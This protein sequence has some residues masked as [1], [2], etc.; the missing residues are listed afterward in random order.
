MTNFWSCPTWLGQAVVIKTLLSVLSFKV[1][2]WAMAFVVVHEIFARARQTSSLRT[3]RHVPAHLVT[4]FDLLFKTAVTFTVV[5]I[6][7]LSNWLV[8]IH[9]L[10]VRAT[11]VA[12][13]VIF[14]FASLMLCLG[15]IGHAES[16]ELRAA[17]A[18]AVD[19]IAR[20]ESKKAMS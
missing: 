1:A 16:L 2:I 12:F 18:F 19:G 20:I 10:S 17:S 14:V 15:A 8:M 11:L 9:T 3:V 5:V 7:V 6:H 13:A 4:I